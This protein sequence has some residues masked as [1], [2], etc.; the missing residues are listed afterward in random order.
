MGEI[1]ELRPSDPLGMRSVEAGP[2]PSPDPIGEATQRL[3]QTLGELIRTL[4]ASHR[5][6]R[7]LIDAIPDAETAAR[8]ARDL[9][10]LS[11]ALRDA[12]AKAA[13]LGLMKS[14]A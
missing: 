2:A 9:A 11:A 5:R 1:I 3:I 7:I 13:S 4:E 10:T 12:K 8:L 6:I 14:D